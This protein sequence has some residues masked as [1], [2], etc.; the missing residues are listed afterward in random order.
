MILAM[1][2]NILSGEPW[3]ANGHRNLSA[4]M[5]HVRYPIMMAT[6]PVFAGFIVAIFRM[7]ELA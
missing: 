4:I 6:H 7:T 1:L 3:K 5:V 2:C